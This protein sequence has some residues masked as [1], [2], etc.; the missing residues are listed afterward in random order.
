MTSNEY[1]GKLYRPATCLILL[2]LY[3][4]HIARTNQTRKHSGQPI[5]CPVIM[6]QI[7][8]PISKSPYKAESIISTSYINRNLCYNYIHLPKKHANPKKRLLTIYN[9][10]TSNFMLPL[11]YYIPVTAEPARLMIIRKLTH[12]FV[13]TITQIYAK[14]NGV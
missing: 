7:P 10:L 2:V 13:L 14:Q 9:I 4:A 6:P 12:I 11:N 8:A 5:Q 3:V 1:L